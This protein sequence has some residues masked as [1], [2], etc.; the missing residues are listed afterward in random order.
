MHNLEIIFFNKNDYTESVDNYSCMRS[1]QMINYYNSDNKSS[2]KL[3][4][5]LLKVSSNRCFYC[6]ENLSSNTTMKVYFEREHIIDKKLNKVIDDTNPKY[7]TLLKCRKNLIPICKNCNSY[8]YLY[9]SKI[10]AAEVPNTCIERFCHFNPTSLSKKYNF[11]LFKI[12][13]FD[14][15]LKLYVTFESQKVSNLN[16]NSR[17]FS[18]Y[19][20]LFS[21][22]YEEEYI[23]TSYFD[24]LELCQNII[25]ETFIKFIYENKIINSE[26]R[27]NS[28]ALDIIIETITLLEI[29]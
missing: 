1:S 21:Q 6:G 23:K 4:K 10:I 28:P 11:D 20:S 25:D 18:V 24:Y 5:D 3:F 14:W 19:T 15:L 27:T 2:Q 8:K 9:N 26:T 13:E 29:N 7:N 12:E 17:L 22:L 16:L